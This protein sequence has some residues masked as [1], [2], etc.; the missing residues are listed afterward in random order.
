MY[1]V[2]KMFS[3][4]VEEKGEISALSEVKG[5]LTLTVNCSESFSKD[6]KIVKLKINEV[7]NIKKNVKF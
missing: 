4:I 2:V 6:K 1:L 3:G 7:R 5:H